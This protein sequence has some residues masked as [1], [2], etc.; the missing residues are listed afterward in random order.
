MTTLVVTR[1]ELE[2]V[3]IRWR[4]WH[5]GKVLIEATRDPE[6]AACRALLELGI[7]GRA[8]TY[9]LGGTAP[10]LRF[11]I[12]ALA[13]LSTDEAGTPRFRSYRAFRPDGVAADG[14]EFSGGIHRREEK[15]AAGGR[16][17]QREI[18]FATEEA[19]S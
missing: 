6:P 14:R 15:T 17:G 18:A 5:L 2:S 16:A 4:V 9:G 12:E 7:T 1:L 3:G 19:A 8:E 10:R 13:E 11:D